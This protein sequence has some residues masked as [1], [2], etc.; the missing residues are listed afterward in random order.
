MDA[1][2]EPRPVPPVPA[3]P[4]V[5]GQGRPTQAWIDYE[6]RLA[7]WEA[8]RQAWLNDLAAAIP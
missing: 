1:F 7:A 6:Q 8:R 4:R 5:D 3:I 2:N